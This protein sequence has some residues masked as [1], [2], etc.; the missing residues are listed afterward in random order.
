[1][2]SKLLLLI[3]CLLLLTSISFFSCERTSVTGDG[4]NNNPNLCARLAALRI[5][6]YVAVTK[7]E[8]IKLSI[9]SIQDA[10]YYWT[11]PG[12]YQSYYQNNTITDYANYYDRGWYYVRV[13]RDGCDPHFDSVFVNVKFPQ[14]TPACSPANNTANFNGGVLL[15]DQSFY[16]LSFGNVLGDYEIEGNSSN[17]DINYKFSA[18]WLTHDLEDGIYY[19]TSTPSIDY[20]DIDRIYISNV[21][22]SIYWVAEPGKPVYVSHVGG[23]QCVTFCGI[24]FSGDWGGTLY[25]TTVNA[26]V[27]QP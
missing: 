8:Q 25:H 13:Y 4:T 3:P 7:G 5:N 21:N 6:S 22:Q 19:T 17:G 11:G 1:M 20:A 15:G 23:K 12:N 18:Y 14:G 2:K 16:F 9:D 27:T 26:K 10:E 24:D